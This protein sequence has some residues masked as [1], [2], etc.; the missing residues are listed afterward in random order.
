[1]TNRKPLQRWLPLLIVSCLC[2]A[3]SGIS[4]V[5]RL[6]A[7][8]AAQVSPKVV[9]V[10]F[11]NERV[12]VLETVSNPGDKELQ[13]SHPAN[14][15]YVIAGGKLRITTADGKTNDVEFKT[16]DTLWRE[17]VTHSAENIGTTQLHAI[18]VELKKP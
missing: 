11:E 10:K 9:K 7:Q 15:L 18:I 3:V 2:L 13:H 5:S 8:D 12:R 14:I 4:G 17:P 6:L 1:M 16:G